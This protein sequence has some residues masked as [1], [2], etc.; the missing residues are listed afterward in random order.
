M[1]VVVKPA[2]YKTGT[3]IVYTSNVPTDGVGVCKA[4]VLFTNTI[5]MFAGINLGE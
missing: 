5:G 3:V 4:G 2:E 1:S